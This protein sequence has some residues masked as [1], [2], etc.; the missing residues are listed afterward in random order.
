MSGTGGMP[1]RLRSASYEACSRTS[2]VE[3]TASGGVRGGIPALNQ[4]Q[5]SQS[6]LRFGS[7]EV[8]LQNPEHREPARCRRDRFLSLPFAIMPSNEEWRNLL[9]RGDLT[10]AEVA[11]FVQDL[12]NFLSQFLDDY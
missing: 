1:C 7:T 4:K 10:D 6:E 5:S 12:R 2:H 11:E 9:A 8:V 3:S